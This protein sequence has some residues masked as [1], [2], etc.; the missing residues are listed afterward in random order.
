MKNQMFIITKKI[1]LLIL[2]EE[3]IT[4]EIKFM[5]RHL[6]LEKFLR[7]SATRAVSSITIVGLIS[8]DGKLREYVQRP[9][10]KYAKKM[11]ANT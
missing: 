3:I 11:M 7:A 8:N 2:G 5:E 10:K 4:D 9:N 1:D 6:G